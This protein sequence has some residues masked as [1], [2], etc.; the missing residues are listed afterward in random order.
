M[1]RV[2]KDEVREERIVMEIIVDTYGPEE[3]A[4]GWYYYLEDN[5]VFPFKTK[6]IMGL[7]T[8]PLTVGQEYEVVNMASEDDCMHDM[9]VEIVWAGRTLAIPLMQVEPIKTDEKTRQ[10]IEDWHYWVARGY[11]F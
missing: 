10:A 11:E 5:L 1:A 2:K 6:C 8:S 4:M 7:K 3:Q 9:L